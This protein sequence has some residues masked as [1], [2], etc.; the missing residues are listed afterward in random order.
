MAIVSGKVLRDDVPVPEAQV[1]IHNRDTGTKLES[2]TQADGS[3]R[4]EIPKL[5]DIRWYALTVVA[6]YSQHSFGWTEV[7]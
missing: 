2:V 4:F 6:Q 5:D 3:F 1:Y 7:S